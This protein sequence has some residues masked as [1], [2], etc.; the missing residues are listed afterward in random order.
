MSSGCCSRRCLLS[1]AHAQPSPSH[2]PTP[3]PPPPPLLL[4]PHTPSH[5]CRLPPP[6]AMMRKYGNG[7]LFGPP[8]QKYELKISINFC[9]ISC[10][11]RTAAR[12][13]AAAAASLSIAATAH[14]FASQ[15][16]Q[17]SIMPLNDWKTGA[18]QT[19]RS[20]G[21]NGSFSGSDSDVLC[22]EDILGGSGRS[23]WWHCRF[24]CMLHPPHTT[25]SD[26]FT[27]KR[28]HCSTL[29]AAVAEVPVPPAAAAIAVAPAAA[30]AAA[31]LPPAPLPPSLV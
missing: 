26:S 3:P 22:L 7:G 9:A 27:A 15:S 21:S 2:N 14:S 6:A 17:T 12:H 18:P 10:T 13:A 28:R 11:C 1:L 16:A 5:L 30:T 29:R 4:P 25:S 19:R 31:P 23:R 20:S 24:Y 8:I